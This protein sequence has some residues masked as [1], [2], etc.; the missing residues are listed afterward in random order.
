MDTSFQSPMQKK[1]ISKINDS[2]YNKSNNQVDT[3]SGSKEQVDPNSDSRVDTHITNGIQKLSI[4]PIIFE[5]V[6][7][8][9]DIITS[10][11]ETSRDG[12]SEES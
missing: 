8:G 2:G 6:V 12:L 11:R 4:R 5:P 10:V 3:I 9:Q 1:Y 7:I